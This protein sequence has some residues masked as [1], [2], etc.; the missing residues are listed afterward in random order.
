[1]VGDDASIES[2]GQWPPT[3]EAATALSLQVWICPGGRFTWGNV[4]A[5]L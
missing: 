1:M 2:S 4:S 5:N 3:S